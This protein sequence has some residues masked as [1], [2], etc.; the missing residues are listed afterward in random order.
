MSKLLAFFETLAFWRSKT[1]VRTQT[2]ALWGES[3]RVPDNF[4]ID[5]VFKDYVRGTVVGQ[6]KAWT[7]EEPYA[8]HIDLDRVAANPP[9]IVLDE[10]SLKWL[11]KQ[12]WM[13]DPRPRPSKA[14]GFLK[15]FRAI[16]DRDSRKIVDLVLADLTREVRQLTTDGRSRG[17]IRLV[18]FR[19]VGGTIAS[20]TWNALD[21]LLKRVGTT[22]GLI[23][24][25]SR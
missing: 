23:K 11:V 22:L 6:V 24:R 18:V 4:D 16:C 1:V 14:I 19:H 3:V 8:A 10:Q 9:R 5:I 15:G 12:G 25:I 20:I 17:F 2:Y 21:A 7:E 13:T